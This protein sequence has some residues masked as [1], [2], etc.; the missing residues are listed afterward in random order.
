MNLADPIMI[1]GFAPGS[2]FLP[3]FEQN[4]IPP[5][6]IPLLKSMPYETALPPLNSHS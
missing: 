6:A 2:N 1:G 3:Q 5:F 4:A